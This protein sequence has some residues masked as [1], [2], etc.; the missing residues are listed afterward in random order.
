MRK[1]KPY[2][3]FLLAAGWLFSGLVMASG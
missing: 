2:K 3:P 1:N